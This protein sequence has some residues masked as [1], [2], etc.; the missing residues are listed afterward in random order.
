[1][2]QWKHRVQYNY[3][4]VG[5][6]MLKCHFCTQ[7]AVGRFTLSDGCVAFPNDKEQDLC[8]HHAMKATPLGTIDLIQDYSKNQNFINYYNVDRN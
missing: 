6:K 2:T 7:E 3:K 5:Y 8:F 4:K 1:L